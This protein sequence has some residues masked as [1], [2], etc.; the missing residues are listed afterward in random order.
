MLSLLL[1]ASVSAAPTAD[2][3]PTAA[4]EPARALVRIIRGAEIRFG[5]AMRL[6]EGVRRDTIVRE[7]DGSVRAAS[8]IEFY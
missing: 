3:P 4:A 1:I 2:R 6:E 8:L 5:E 7:R